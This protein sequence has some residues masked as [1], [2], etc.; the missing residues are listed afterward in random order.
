MKVF[1]QAPG[2]DR[3]AAG[4]SSSATEKYCA[5]A[6]SEEEGG[7][8][9]ELGRALHFAPVPVLAALWSRG[10]ARCGNVATTAATACSSCRH[11]ERRR[12]SLTG[13]S[14]S[15]CVGQQPCSSV[16]GN[17]HKEVTQAVRACGCFLWWWW[18]FLRGVHER[19][20]V[21]RARRVRPAT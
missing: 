18:W 9:P 17:A 16:I 12:R 1:V 5:P 7:L 21:V 6:A 10:A 11:H 20:R 2:A 15:T 4:G 14:P 19:A 8:L 13:P 3:S